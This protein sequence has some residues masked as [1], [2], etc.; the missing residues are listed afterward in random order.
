MQDRPLYGTYSRRF[1][2]CSG[3][4]LA[5]TMSVNRIDSIRATPSINP[6]FFAASHAIK[7]S[8]RRESFIQKRLG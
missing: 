3:H 6:Y 5:N 1:C 7:R 4:K 8:E 2:W